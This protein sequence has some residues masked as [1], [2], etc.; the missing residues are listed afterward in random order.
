MQELEAKLDGHI[1]EHKDDFKRLE[2]S[3]RA[4]WWKVA[5]IVTIPLIMGFVGY[6]ALTNQ[7]ETQDKAI[8]EIKTVKANKETVESQY[9]T[10]IQSIADLKAEIRA[11]KKTL[12]LP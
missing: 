1:Q 7:V 4:I 3:F 6:G 9:A 11:S 5:G 2:D 10:I 12:D 8:Q